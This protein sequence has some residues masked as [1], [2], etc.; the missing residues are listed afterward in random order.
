MID[1]SLLLAVLIAV[2]SGGET[3]PDLAV[4][5]NGK[6][7]GCLQIQI[8]VIQDV[9]RIYRRNF[10]PSDRNNRQYSKLIAKLWLTYYGN[11]YERRTGIEPTYEIYCRLWNGGYKGLLDRPHATDYYWN[12]CKGILQWQKHIT[13]K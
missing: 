10:I 2:E 9:N 13:S 4:G 1:W 12:K 8:P 3:H 11:K 7:I 6:S 5:D